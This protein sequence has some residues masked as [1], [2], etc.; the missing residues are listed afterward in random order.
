MSM[1]IDTFDDYTQREN[2]L[3]PFFKRA[4][5]DRMKYIFYNMSIYSAL[6]EMRFYSSSAFKRSCHIQKGTTKQPLEIDV[7]QL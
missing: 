4:I 3:N 7:P 6:I 5:C 2:K 1:D